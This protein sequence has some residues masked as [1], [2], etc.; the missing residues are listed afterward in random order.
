MPSLSLPPD[1]YGVPEYVLATSTT[2]G[3]SELYEPLG[4]VYKVLLEAGSLFLFAATGL[5]T[6][7]RL[8]GW[9]AAATR[10]LAERFLEFPEREAE[11]DGPF[12][13]VSHENRHMEKVNMQ[14][15]EKEICLFMRKVLTGNDF[16]YTNNATSVKKCKV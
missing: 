15:M 3:I 9:R 4:R 2:F 8:T 1:L 7:V 12:R 11:S 14:M 5:L 6:G 16:N 13:N 10:E